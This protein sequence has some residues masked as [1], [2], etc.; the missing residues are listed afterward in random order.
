MTK[1]TNSTLPPARVTRFYGNPDYA[2]ETLATQQIT[3]VHVSRLNDPFDPY[4]F[5]ETDFGDSHQNLLNYIKENH[6]DKVSWLKQLP[7]EHWLSAI[8][9]VRKELDLLRQQIFVFSTSGPQDGIHP[10]ENLYMWGHYGKGHRGIAIEFASEELSS[11]ALKQPTEDPNLNSHEV[12]FPM[13]YRK[14]IPRVTCEAFIEFLKQGTEGPDS[15]IQGSKKS[16]LEEHFD[17]ITKIKSDVWAHENEWRLMWKNDETRMKIHRCPIP[18]KAITRIFLG[19]SVS[20]QTADDVIFEAKQKLPSAQIFRA[21][22]RIGEF[23]LDFEQ[24][25]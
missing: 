18:A 17:E 2:L 22:K 6:P 20:K 9:A 4:L 24:V 10:Q 7:S 23:A 25:A 1:H 3:F 13:K 11:A 5:F 21:R 15:K 14:E 12:W 8:E 19:L 16:Q